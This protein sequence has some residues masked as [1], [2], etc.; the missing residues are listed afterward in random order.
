MCCS[1]RCPQRKKSMH[2]LDP[3]RTT[4]TLRPSRIRSKN[5]AFED[6][7]FLT[8]IPGSLPIVC[9]SSPGTAH[10]F[11][12]FPVYST[13][14]LNRDDRLDLAPGQFPSVSHTRSWLP[15]MHTAK[16]G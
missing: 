10:P 12:I 16:R 8:L 15:R 11:P 1:I 7:V 5:Y 9:R 14:S 6:A 2:A 4:H 13:A 3:L